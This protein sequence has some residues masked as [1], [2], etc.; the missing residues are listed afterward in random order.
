MSP[1]SGPMRSGI[2]FAEHCSTGPLRTLFR[3]RELLRQ[4]VI[5]EIKLRYKRSALGF[6]WTV[7]NPLLAMAI[8]TMVFSRI[9]GDRPYYSLYVFTALLGWNLFSLG[10]SRG[11]DS[12]VLNGPIIRK[13]F[14][15]KA[16]FPVASVVSQVVNFIF[17]LI[18]LFLL[19]IVIRAG[20]SL[21][22]FWLPIALLSLTCFALGI[23]LLLG[24]FNVFFRD[25]KYFYEAGLL[26]W[27]YATPIFYPAEII[28][29]EFKFL[30]YVNPMYALLESLRAPI[31]QGAAPG[32]VVLVSGLGLSLATLAVGWIVFH[33]FESRFIHYV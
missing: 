9:F 28:P 23:A 8:F 19:M 32:A 5:R 7:L 2:Y 18:P 11:L 29:S 24:T 3:Y 20:F 6:A 21:S 4:L 13:V 30:L 1:G 22:L 15:P 33:R 25:V 12:V 26:A 27:F 10:T 31:Y 17:T 16:I 14:V